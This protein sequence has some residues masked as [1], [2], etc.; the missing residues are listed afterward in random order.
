MG[1]RAARAW[2]KIGSSGE[3]EVSR[4]SQTLA[5][6]AAVARAPSCLSAVVKSAFIGCN[7]L[8][9]PPLS[10]SPQR[11]ALLAL[12]TR[13]VT[14]KKNIVASRCTVLHEPRRNAPDRFKGRKNPRHY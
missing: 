8:S 5:L 3:P 12:M 7:N 14:G 10:P 6:G 11:S 4:M 9:H 1:A 13:R 2:E